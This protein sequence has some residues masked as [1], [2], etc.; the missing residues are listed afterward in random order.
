MTISAKSF[1]ILMSGFKDLFKFSLQRKTPPPGD[2][3]F[4]YIFVEGHIADP[5][6]TF[7]HFK[8]IVIDQTSPLD[9]I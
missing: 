1:L 9:Q 8:Q 3:V 6:S 4:S 5:K 7:E 2:Y